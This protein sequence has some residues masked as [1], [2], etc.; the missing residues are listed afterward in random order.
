MKYKILL[1]LIVLFAAVLRFY[2]ISNN[3]PGLYIDEVSIGYNA[4]SI[5]TTGKDEHNVS[6]PL[7]FKAFGE[8]KMPVYIYATATSIKF[9]GKNEF[10]VRFPSALFGTLTVF[11]L[12]FL[13]KEL[14]RLDIKNK[15]KKKIEIIALI[16]A[17]LLAISPWH[18]QFSRAGF[19]ATAA[20][21]FYLLANLFVL[22]FVRK[23]QYSFLVLSIFFYAL[24]MYTYDGYRIL[25][26]VTVLAAFVWVVLEK[27]TTKT[28]ISLLAI[29]FFL[30][31]LPLLQFSL[32]AQGRERFSQ[33]SAFAEYKTVSLAD[34]VKIYPMFFV[35][36]YTSYFSSQFLFVS[37]DGIGRHQMPNFGE[38][39]LWQF[40]FLLSGLFF[41]VRLNGRVKYLILFLLFVAPLPAALARPNPH[42]LRSL[43][44][45]IP[46]VTITA[47]GIISLLT[48][49][50]KY[51]FLI[52]IIILCM[53]VYEFATY[54]HF[55]YVHYPKSNSLDWGAQYKEVIQKTAR[56][57]KDHSPIV[58][59]KSVG[60]S[61]IY[62]LFYD[63]TIHPLYVGKNWH[64]PALEKKY[65]ILYIRQFAIASSGKLLDSVYLNNIN[66]DGFVHLWEL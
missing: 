27:Y 46:F 55:Y 30:L 47:F 17:F 22:F 1:F 35:K 58:I 39:P 59:D 3:P 10:A 37:G 40:P 54:L 8:Y 64:N 21:F 14:F 57:K 29:L 28:K 4:Y 43:P 20:L 65:N 6:H 15:Q 52:G 25:T 31:S 13:I 34:Y 63:N 49:Y 7:W 41:L 2:H 9:F 11:L 36:N 51:A 60:L 33:T 45:V 23:K 38:L 61:Y 66:R 48:Q 26:P 19:E 42:A 12:Y 56:Y 18:L 53:G 32:T 44:L 24:T 16:C 5:L 62:F 50:K